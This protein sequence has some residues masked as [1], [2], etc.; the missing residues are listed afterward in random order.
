MYPA[1]L[2]PTTQSSAERQLY[3]AFARQLD[4]QW[5]IFHS[6]KWL[7][8]QGRQPCDGETDFVV[9]HPQMGILVIE[10][11]GGDIRFDEG[12]EHYSS[13]NSSGY[14]VDIGDPFDKATADKHLLISKLR[15]TPHFPRRRIVFGH[16]VA[17]CDAVVEASWLRPNAPREIIID[18]LDLNSIEERLRSA[19]DFW[20]GKRPTDRVPDSA[21]D[22]PPGNDGVDSL[23]R[24]LGQSRRI[25]HPMLAER[26]RADEKHIVRLTESQYRYLRFLSGQ[27]RAAIAGCAGSGKTLLAVEKARSLAEDEGLDVL[28]T[29]YNRALA[30][31]VGD[32]LGY[33]GVFDVFSFHQL[34]F[35]TAQ[36]AGKPVPYKDY[37]SS[38]YY[39]VELPNALLEATDRLG[40]QYDAIIVDE[41]QDFLAEW[42][43]VLPLLL[44]DPASGVLYA[45]FD[46]NQRVYPD[47]AQIP[48]EMAPY[49]LNENCRNTRR[50]FR[51][52]AKFYEGD[53]Q[54]V[55]LGP[56]GL[57][58]EI[59]EYADERTSR[60]RLRRTLHH[61]LTEN[62]FESNE[63]A[64]LT[65]R[66]TN[67]SAIL[68][69]RLDPFQLTDELPLKIGDVFATTIR[70]FKGL[71]RPAIVLCE[72]DGTL[73]GEEIE[74]LMYVGTSRAKAYLAILVARSAP[75]HVRESLL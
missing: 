30:D 53:E 39:D 23:V 2:D 6:V 24:L 55:V 40:S 37:Q 46:N 27:R 58:V 9:A 25:R 10:V 49:V 12:T 50:I 57:A 62:R 74:A 42:W 75:A 13:T 7:D 5:V 52:V 66:G 33:R 8:T 59:I 1:L 69:R 21:L 63:V 54:P 26:A 56:E 51:T 3:G 11:K 47:R 16:M 29:C 4:D 14:V 36:R 61:L 44:H 32:F 43:R 22:T 70:R 34:C 60:S 18:A 72:I 19:M 71:D 15:R 35:R 65:A 45:F 17:F 64:V 73:T 38:K 41:G 48:I 28:F 20:R 31:H 68:G 67:S